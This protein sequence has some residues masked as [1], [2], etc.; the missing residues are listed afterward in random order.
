VLFVVFLPFVALAI[1]LNSG[2]PVFIRQKRVGKDGKTF[3]LI[4]FRSMYHDQI[5]NPD[6]DA[7]IPTWS[8]GDRDKRITAVG[9]FLRASHIDELPQVINI[10]RGEMSVVGPRPER[11]EFVAELEKVIPYYKMRHLV[12]PGMTGWAQVKY[13]YGASVED[14]LEKLQYELYYLKHRSLLIYVS[15]LGKTA[16]QII[17]QAVRK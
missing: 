5:I 10:F 3:T 7:S 9:K 11:P 6:A 1:R 14:A 12:K 2:G 15:V 4:K 17:M 16:Q 13:H 8:T